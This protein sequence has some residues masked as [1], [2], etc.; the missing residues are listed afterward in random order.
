MSVSTIDYY[1][2]LNIQK[3]ASF[4]EI[5]KSFRVLAHKFHPDKNPDNSGSDDRFKEISKAY[6]VLSDPEKRM[7]YDRT[8]QSIDDSFHDSGGMQ[9]GM[10]CGGKRGCGRGRRGGSAAWTQRMQNMDIHEVTVTRQEAVNGAEISIKPAG[11]SLKEAFQIR[12]PGNMQN[13][14]IL[15]CMRDR[16]EDV[17]F[18]RI[19]IADD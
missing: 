2:L 17:F 12:L 18:I 1:T 5:K 11:V 8:G 14:T 3:D 6:E 13:G 16:S 4:D 9:G 19:V 15:Q 10:G 7:M